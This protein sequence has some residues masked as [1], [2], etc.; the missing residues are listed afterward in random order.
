MLLIYQTLQD[1][2]EGL[3][4]YQEALTS[5]GGKAEQTAEAKDIINKL[6]SE[7]EAKMLDD[8]N[9][10]HILTGAYQDALKFVNASLSKLKV[11]T[12][13]FFFICASCIHKYTY[14]SCLVF[15]KFS[16]NAEEAANVYACVTH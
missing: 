1:L 11:S 6:K 15:F 14:Q 5:E 9:T 4:P 12:F 13:V 2:V 3:S 7:F 8:L 16:E 10:A